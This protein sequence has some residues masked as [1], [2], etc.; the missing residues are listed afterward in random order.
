MLYGVDV[1]CITDTLREAIEDD[2]DDDLQ[3]NTVNV[4]EAA[5][6]GNHSEQSRLKIWRKKG[7]LRKLHNLIVHARM[8]S[9]RRRIFA[10][11]Q[12]ETADEVGRL[13]ELIVDGG[14]RWNSTHD[15]IERALKLEDAIELYQ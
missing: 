5:L 2:E 13:F 11:K 6:R 10:L 14:V 1:D 12:R 4:F 15:M 8:T 3:T 7:P 9:A